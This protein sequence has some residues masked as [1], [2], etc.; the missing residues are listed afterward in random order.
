MNSN[1]DFRCWERKFAFNT[2]IEGECKIGETKQRV[3]MTDIRVQGSKF[4]EG[5]KFSK[6]EG[7][8]SVVGL[9]GLGGMTPCPSPF[10]NV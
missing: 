10:G 8:G 6:S 7:E 5:A 9:R 4:R 1:A 3:S 2:R